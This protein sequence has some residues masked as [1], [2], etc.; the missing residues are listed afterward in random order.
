MHELLHLL[1]PYQLHSYLAEPFHLG[2]AQSAH[3]WLYEG[4][5]E[6]F[7]LL[8]LVRY[9]LISEDNFWGEMGKKIAVSRTAPLYPL[10]DIS[11]FANRKKYAP[12]YYQLYYKGALTAFLL[13]IELHR[14]KA[15]SKKLPG[16]LPQWIGQLAKQYGIEKHF[17]DY[18]LLDK[19]VE[20]T[21]STEI[22]DFFKHYLT[23]TT[24][25][26]YN[27]Y[28]ASLG[29]RYHDTFTDTVGTFGAVALYPNYKDATLY[30]GRTTDNLLGLQKGDVLL[31]LNGRPVSTANAE[32]V[33]Q[34]LY[35]PLP[36]QST[37]VEV[38][39]QA[40]KVVLRAV[41]TPM[42]Q[43]QQ[44]TVQP[45]R[46]VSPTAERLREQLLFGGKRLNS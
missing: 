46:T 38:L 5:T 19:L 4:V 35:R 18:L 12:Y 17:N 8:A 32:S 41:P 25:L 39:R 40:K 42:L 28:L 36:Y 13:D 26:P 45:L 2:A 24:S 31:N 44:H 33:R 3:G 11:R 15:D 20:A 27:D 16:N 21:Q 7:T 37:T 1:A 43:T 34:Q 29:M 10:T 14:L 9:G 6:Y 30:I 23:G 22:A